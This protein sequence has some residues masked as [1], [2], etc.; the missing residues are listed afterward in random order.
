[1]LSVS[2]AGGPYGE[3]L[4]RLLQGEGVHELQ[5][6]IAQEIRENFSVQAALEIIVRGQA[7][8]VV[9]SLGAEGAMPVTASQSLQALA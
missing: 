9:L 3:R 7:Q 6:P 1:M 8:V 4:H 2:P 5:P